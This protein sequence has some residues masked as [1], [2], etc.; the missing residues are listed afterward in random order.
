M[1]FSTHILSDLE[2]IAD[3]IYFIHNGKKIL[4][5][6]KDELLENF[7]LVKGSRN[8]VH[9]VLNRELIGMIQNAYGFEAILPSDKADLIPAGLVYEK[10]VIDQ[11]VIHFIKAQER[12]S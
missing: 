8:A 11:I 10:P 5:D 3:Y 6:T 4:Y 1:L 12:K 2:Q 9:E 7:L